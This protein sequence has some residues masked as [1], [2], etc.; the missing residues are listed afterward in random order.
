MVILFFVEPNLAIDTSMRGT[1]KRVITCFHK[2]RTML[3]PPVFL[4]GATS[5]HLLKQSTATT[6]YSRLPLAFGSFPTRSIPHS[7]WWLRV[8]R[9]DLL[10]HFVPEVCVLAQLA[11]TLGQLDGCSMAN[12]L[13]HTLPHTV[14]TSPQGGFPDRASLFS[15]APSPREEPTSDITFA[16]SSDY[17]LSP[18]CPMLLETSA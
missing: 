6:A 9:D 5:T 2:N 7:E 10:L 3:S 18:L 15:L 17:H 12:C 16:P 4:R 8:L 13:L 1:P 14:W 11:E